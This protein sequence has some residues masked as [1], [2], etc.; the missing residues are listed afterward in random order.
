MSA[1]TRKL[2]G[3]IVLLAGLAVY[4]AAIVSLFTSALAEAPKWFQ[5]IYFAGA[6]VLWAFPAKYLIQWMQKPEPE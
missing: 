5:L 2:I 1:R 3:M 6:G 4:V